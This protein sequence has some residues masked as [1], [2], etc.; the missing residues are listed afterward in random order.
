MNKTQINYAKERIEIIK[1]QHLRKLEELLPKPKEATWDEKIGEILSGKATLKV[2]AIT[3]E[4][5]ESG[6]PYWLKG[7]F[8]YYDFDSDIEDTTNMDIYEKRS[9]EIKKHIE[10]TAMFYLDQIVLDGKTDATA[11][12][13]FK[14]RNFI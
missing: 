4:L 2:D 13:E 7:I 10:D 12:D 9:K 5:E 11:L 1:N 6:C 14:K 8:Q 3:R